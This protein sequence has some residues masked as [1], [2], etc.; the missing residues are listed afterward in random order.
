MQDITHN[1]PDIILKNIAAHNQ[2]NAD[3]FIA[4]FASDALVNDAKREF[5]GHNA[6]RAW[7]QKEIFDDNVTMEVSKAYAN[8]GNII[9]HAIIAGDFDKSNLPDPVILTYYF[10]IQNDKITQLMILLNK[11][12]W[13]SEQ[14]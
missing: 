14:V 4:T 3:A 12:I 2:R 6:I 9:V 10:S 5:V 7:A 8:H 11:V 1:F 13:K